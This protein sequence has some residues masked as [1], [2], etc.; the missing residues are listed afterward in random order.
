MLSLFAH[1]GHGANM[2]VL[3]SFVIGKIV[4]VLAINI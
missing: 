2:S 1:S 4:E 3:L